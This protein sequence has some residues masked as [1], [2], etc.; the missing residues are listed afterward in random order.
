MFHPENH[1]DPAIIAPIQARGHTR[2]QDSSLQDACGKRTGSYSCRL[3]LAGAHDRL[4][5]YMRDEIDNQRG[6]GYA[7]DRSE[8]PLDDSLP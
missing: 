3:L 2:N 4:Q 7:H 8:S 6:Q 5:Y 1:R